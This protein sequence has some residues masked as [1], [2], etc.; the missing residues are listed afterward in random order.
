LSNIGDSLKIPKSKNIPI[1]SKRSSNLEYITNSNGSSYSEKF[2]DNSF[3]N[4]STLNENKISTING[5][6]IYPILYSDPLDYNQ[7]KSSSGNDSYSY[8]INIKK[9]LIKEFIETKEKADAEMYEIYS[10]WLEDKDSN[11]DNDELGS[12]IDN[13]VFGGNKLGYGCNNQ[14]SSL[15]SLISI[16]LSNGSL[17]NDH[18]LYFNDSN[19]SLF[20]NIG[21][22]DSNNS[23]HQSFTSLFSNKGNSNI[24]I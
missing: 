14:S 22:I 17:N 9:N 18:N 5:Q 8:I 4:I 23:N 19:D 24:F 7:N 10:V 15:S 2:T 21:S 13:E 12:N 3:S 1:S 16:N 6:Q 11:F 20:N